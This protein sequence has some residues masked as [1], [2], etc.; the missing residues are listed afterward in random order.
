LL[1]HE[2]I[3]TFVGV[4]VSSE[5][6]M[7][8]EYYPNGSILKHKNVSNTAKMI[9]IY[10]IAFGMNLLHWRRIMHRNLKPAN[11][12]LDAHMHPRICDFA[13][14]KDLTGLNSMNQTGMIGTTGFMA[15]E[16][17]QDTNI[18]WPAD[19]FA[20]GMTVWAIITEQVPFADHPNP[21][22]TATAINN[23]TRPPIPAHLPQLCKDL[24]NKCW[25]MNPDARLTFM[26]IVGL[27]KARGPLLND[28]DEAQ[29][30]AYRQLLD[31]EHHP[32]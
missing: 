7:Y 5:A 29:Y 18:S 16:V 32:I 4:S 2:S 22:R 31:G 12:M 20:F 28:V 3:A 21:V 24:I 9:W 1:V 11:V 8:I 26:E 10:G 19:V 15:P 25:A 14:S 23:G 30:N 6:T 17:L 13:L 27:M